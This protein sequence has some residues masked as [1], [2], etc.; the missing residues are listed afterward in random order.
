MR[1]TKRQQIDDLS[2]RYSV[3]CSEFVFGNQTFEF[4]YVKDPDEMLDDETIQAS[5]AELAW[6]PYWAQLWDAALGL[7]YELADRDLRDL[8]VLDLGCGLGVTGAVAA[9]Q[10]ASVVLADNAPPAL[11]FAALN[12]DPWRDQVSIQLVDWKKDKLDDQFDLIVG[13]DIIYDPADIEPL[14]RFWMA[15]LVPQGRLLLSEP[16]RLLTNALMK[17]IETLGWN[18][19][20]KVRNIEVRRK[21]IRIFELRQQM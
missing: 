7:C 21:Q 20:T 8:R 13:S 9:S 15:T 3:D 14:S 6:Q 2:S 18:C 5:H 1:K 17:K 4:W 16:T 11:E 10:G 19:Q 12:C